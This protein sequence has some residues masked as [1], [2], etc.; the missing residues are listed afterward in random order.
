MVSKPVFPATFLYDQFFFFGSISSFSDTR[1]GSVFLFSFHVLLHVDPSFLY[2]MYSKFGPFEIFH[3]SSSYPKYIHLVFTIQDFP[4]IFSILF[5][6]RTHLRYPEEKPGEKV[7]WTPPRIRTRVQLGG[8]HRLYPL[9]KDSL[10]LLN[11]R[12]LIEYFAGTST[13]NFL[14]KCTA[15]FYNFPLIIIQDRKLMKYQAPLIC[16]DNRHSYHRF[17]ARGSF[18]ESLNFDFCF[19]LLHFNEAFSGVR[20][21]NLCQTVWKF[22]YAKYIP[23]T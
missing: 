16:V 4:N 21:V 11:S 6:E 15:R 20:P 17:Q 5:F 10:V 19:T 22:E 14:W 12:F 1:R 13:W 2:F 18:Y 7:F 3:L 9:C 8:N 23:F